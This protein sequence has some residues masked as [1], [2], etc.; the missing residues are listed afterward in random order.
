MKIQ[1]CRPA[2][3]QKVPGCRLAPLTKLLLL[4]SWIL[5][6]P[7]C[8]FFHDAEYYRTAERLRG[9]SR[10]AVFIQRWPCYLQLNQQTGMGDEFIKPH[11]LFYGPWE[12][13]GNLSPRAVDVQDI[14][15]CLMEEIL[16]H[17]LKRKGY[18][19]EV[20]AIGPGPATGITVAQIMA[21]YQAINPEVK[22]FLFCFYSPTVY[23]AD[24]GLTPAEHG[25]RPFSL[26]E[27]IGILNP[28][29]RWVMWAGKRAALAPPRSISHAYIY[30]SLSL[31]SA[32]KWQ[33]LWMT[34]DSRVGGTVRPFLVECPPEPTKKAYRADAA[35]I[36]RIMYDNLKCRLGHL[37]PSAF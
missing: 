18:Q 4:A 22:A 36:S 12:P 27:V 30:V 33:P 5:C 20:A 6:L 1:N 26:L 25:C 29:G 35:I 24:A 3:L 31:F 15:D 11:T 34:A 32:W 9:T 7:S 19:P 28:G 10:V 13:D 2:A 21:R 14:D 37:I 23:L 17:E 16:V 8:V